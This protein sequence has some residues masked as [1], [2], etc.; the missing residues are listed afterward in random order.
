MPMNHLGLGLGLGLQRG[1]ASAPPVVAPENTVLPAISGNAFVGS[2][3]TATTGTWLNGVDTFAYQWK[4]DGTNVGLNQNTYVPV[5]GDLG[6]VITVVVT[7]TNAGGSTP[8]GST[9]TSAVIAVPVNTVAP[10]ITGNALVGSTLTCST[11]TWSGGGSQTYA[12]QWK[13]AGSNVGSNQNTYVPVT[14]DVGDTITCTVTA[15]NA[16]GSGTPVESAATAA[17]TAAPFQ[18]MVPSSFVNISG[19]RQSMLPTGAFLNEG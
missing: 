14:D 2:T 18:A 5:S 1:G 12:Y 19:S 6:K 15:T 3:L 11:G 4:A 17:V 8:A 9:A 13:S 7:A 16:A 10:A